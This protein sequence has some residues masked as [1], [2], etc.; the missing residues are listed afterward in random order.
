[1]VRVRWVSDFRILNRNL[2]RKQYELPRIRDILERRS[3]YN[4]FTKLD[5]S[6]QYYTFQLDEASKQLCTIITPFGHYKYNRL[7]MGI[8]EAPAIAQEIMEDTLRDCDWS[9]YS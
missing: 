3:G 2:Q 6:M 9:M 8:S 5:I 1:M 4:F 7:P